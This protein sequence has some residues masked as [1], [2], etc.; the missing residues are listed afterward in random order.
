NRVH[1]P[2]FCAEHSH[3]LPSFE[4]ARDSLERLEDFAQFMNY[5]K[6]NLA[7]GAKLGL[8]AVLAVGAAFPLA[9]MAAP[10][11]GGAVGVLASKMGAGAALTGAAAQSF[12][13]A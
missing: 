3:T 2:S 9:L 11:V 5:D 13:L 4:R 8:T 12:G 1:L 7:K 6:P 10:A